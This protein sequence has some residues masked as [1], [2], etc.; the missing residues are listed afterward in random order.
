M[1]QYKLSNLLIELNDHLHMMIMIPT[2]RKKNVIHCRS[3]FIV[4]VPHYRPQ[5]TFNR[6]KIAGVS[7]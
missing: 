2:K 5:Y 3:S 7:T 4:S 1:L 6:I